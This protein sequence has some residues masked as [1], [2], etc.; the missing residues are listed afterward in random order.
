[1]NGAFVFQERPRSDQ[2]AYLWDLFEGGQRTNTSESFLR[3]VTIQDP[4]LSHVAEEQTEL[5]E[6]SILPAS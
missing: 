1:M 2:Y 4:D 6:I 5:V 3:A